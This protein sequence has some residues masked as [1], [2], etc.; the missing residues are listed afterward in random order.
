MK[1]KKVLI[2]E[3]DSKIADLVKLYLEKEGFQTAAAFDGKEGLELAE[4][5]GPDFIVLDLMLPK[6][7]GM[8]IAKQIRRKSNVPILMLTAKSE[9]FDKV[10]GLEMGADDY[11]TKP[12][13][14]KE[15]VARVKAILRRAE[16]NQETQL[17]EKIRIKDLEIDQKKFQAK[18]NSKIINLSALEFRLLFAL[19]SHPGQVFSRGEL[20]H[21]IYKED[22]EIVFDRTIDVHI[23]NL[24]KKLKDNPRRPTYIETVSG[25]GYK[26]KEDYEI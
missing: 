9:E 5:E 26:F 7:G 25:V 13:S 1:N 16:I 24:R 11:L 6:I 15:L 14:P 18:K 20:M 23:K 3:D 12:F 10:L 22:E 8:D 17:S 19:A 4:K 21:K 2:I